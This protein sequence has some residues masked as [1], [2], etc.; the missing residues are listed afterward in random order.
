VRGLLGEGTDASGNMFQISNQMT[1]G[2]SEKSIVDRLTEVVLEV[3]G[4]EK[5]CAGS[6]A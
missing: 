4:H 6:P 2:E 5:K 3:A 1:L